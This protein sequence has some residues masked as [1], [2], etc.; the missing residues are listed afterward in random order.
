MGFLSGNTELLKSFILCTDGQFMPYEPEKDQ[1]WS[2]NIEKTNHSPFYLHTTYGLRAV[3]MRVFPNL[4]I[5]NQQILDENQLIQQPQVTAYTPGYL[6]LVAESN[7][8]LLKFDFFLPEPEVLVGTIKVENKTEKLIELTVEMAAILVPM[9]NG[10]PTRA[11]K[12]GVHHIVSGITENLCPVLFMNSGPIGVN[13]PYPALSMSMTL[14]AYEQKE[15]T[16]ALVSKASRSVSFAKAQSI[17][18]SD[19]KRMA[20]VQNKAGERS[21]IDIRT[22]NPDWDA[23]FALAQPTA[24]THLAE[25]AHAKTKPLFLRARLPDVPLARQKNIREMDDLTSLEAVHLSQVILPAHSEILIG[26]VEK[27]LGHLQT[28]K[29]LLSRVNTSPF[30]HAHPELP[31]LAHLCLELYKI[32]QDQHLLKAVFHPLCKIID[33]WLKPEDKNQTIKLPSWES[34]SQLQIESG[35]YPFEHWGE[36]A[37]GIDTKTVASPAL[38]SLLYAETMAMQKISGILGEEKAQQ[39]FQSMANALEQ[40]LHEFWDETGQIFTYRDQQSFRSPSHELHLS[41]PAQSTIQ[42][43]KIF[44]EPQRLLCHLFAVDEKTKVCSIQLTGKDE[45]GSTIVEVF[46]NDQIHWIMKTAHLTS[47]NLFSTLHSVNTTGLKEDDRFEIETVDLSKPDITCLLPLWSGGIEQEH[48]K[49][50]A[51]TFLDPTKEDFSTGIPEVWQ[52]KHKL[53]ENLPVFINIIWNTFIIEGL[54]NQGYPIQAREHFKNLMDTISSALKNYKA[55]Y[56]ANEKASKRP[57]GGANAI[58]GL[59]PLRLFLKIAGIQLFSPDRI[60]LWGENPFPWPIEVHWQG[61]SIIKEGLHTRVTFPSGANM[62]NDSA[63]PV[64][65]SPHQK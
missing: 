15:V 2:F 17:L 64:L 65:L 48:L 28:E 27:Y 23:A 24:M 62:V 5:G 36:S 40:A 34:P 39:N 41:I 60:A 37:Q 11:E 7:S 26:Q 12:E 13:N 22:G 45:H 9:K 46:K 57:A 44:S 56:A 30:I 16:W 50:L 52:G 1:V 33:F 31:L 19:W 54:L 49:I 55:F 59:P 14:P 8:L 18:T 29:T 3:S 51:E 53:P 4:K 10:S 43:N 25:G 6:C 20:N 35:L 61:L 47:K 32:N 63:E 21:F 38:V 42:V 58:G